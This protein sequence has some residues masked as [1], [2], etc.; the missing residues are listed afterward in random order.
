MSASGSM[1]IGCKRTT[2]RRVCRHL[3]D[4]EPPLPRQTSSDRQKTMRGGR[5]RPPCCSGQPAIGREP[6]ERSSVSPEYT[7]GRSCSTTQFRPLS[8]APHRPNGLIAQSAST[9][10]RMSRSNS[11]DPERR[12]N[13][14]PQLLRT[15]RRCSWTRRSGR[16][17]AGRGKVQDGRRQSQALG[18]RLGRDP[19]KPYTARRSEPLGPPPPAEHALRKRRWL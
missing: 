10:R 5:R 14:P 2:L 1:R 8:S 9:Q 19:A 15:S 3:S 13:S 7:S 4:A 18:P 17:S 12:F 6:S 11:R 16:R